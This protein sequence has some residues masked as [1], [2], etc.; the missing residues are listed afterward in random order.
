[1]INTANDGGLKCK[2]FIDLEEDRYADRDGD[3]DLD[4]ISD[5]IV[6]ETVWDWACHAPEALFISLHKTSHRN[7]PGTFTKRVTVS[8]NLPSGVEKF[9]CTRSA[10]RV[11]CKIQEVKQQQPGKEWVLRTGFSRGVRDLPYL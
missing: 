9:G 5:K 1:M 7:E 11:F 8:M 10:L 4:K 6:V 2:S 3:P